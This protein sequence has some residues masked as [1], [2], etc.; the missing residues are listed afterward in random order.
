MCLLVREGR[1]LESLNSSAEETSTAENEARAVQKRK[2]EQ[3]AQTSDENTANRAL[4]RRRIALSATPGSTGGG[5]RC[6]GDSASAASC[7]TGGIGGTVGGHLSA[8]D[9]RQMSKHI[10]TLFIP[11]IEQLLAVP[12]AQDYFGAPVDPIASGALNYLEVIN[13]P[14]DLGTILTRLHSSTYTHVQDLLDDVHLVFENACTY[15]PSGT[16]V[17]NLSKRLR[18]VFGWASRKPRFQLSELSSSGQLQLS[19]HQQQ[20]AASSSSGSAVGETRVHHDVSA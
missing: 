6:S 18:T 13:R 10:S 4:P 16:I 14:M 5:S 3:G 7:G 8:V 12:L 1:G 20:Q 17:S 11:V 9:A 15:N 2:L 19:Q